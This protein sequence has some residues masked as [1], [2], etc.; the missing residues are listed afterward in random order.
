MFPSLQAKEERQGDTVLVGR[1]MVPCSRGQE[2]VHR[3]VLSQTQLHRVHSLL[4]TWAPPA[5]PCT[6]PNTPLL[7]W[8]QGPL[9]DQQGRNQEVLQ[10]E[11][12]FIV[13]EKHA[14]LCQCDG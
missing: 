8:D 12:I 7:R 5:A 3:L 14:D 4:R 11:R 6:P 2:Q 1:V 13:C 10:E 9:Q